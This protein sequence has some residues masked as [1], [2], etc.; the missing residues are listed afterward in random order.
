[1]RSIGAACCYR[2]SSVIC[3]LGTLAHHAKP[4][5]QQVSRVGVKTRVGQ[6][7]MIIWGVRILPL[8][9]ALLRN[10]RP[11]KKHSIA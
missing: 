4:A 2:Q 6:G 7:M 11:I 10:V 5:E 9:G 1:M 3:V 8:E